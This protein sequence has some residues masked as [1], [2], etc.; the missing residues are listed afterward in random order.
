MNDVINFNKFIVICDVNL[1][2]LI[3]AVFRIYDL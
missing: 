1:C 2:V 3:Q